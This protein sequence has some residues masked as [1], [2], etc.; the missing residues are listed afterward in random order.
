M[1]KKIK[2]KT[3]NSGWTDPSKK[4]KVRKKRKPMTE[5][6]KQ[7]A[8]ERLEKA[9]AARAAKNPNYGQSGVHESLRDL[10]DDAPIN[11]KKVKKWIKTQKELASME[12]RNEKKNVKGAFARKLIHEGYVR[13]MQKYLRDGDWVDY[14]YG[15]HQEKKIGYIC[16]AQAYYWEGPKKGEPKFNVGTYYPLLGTVYSQEMYN[17]DNG[18]QDVDVQK[19]KTRKRK[20]NK[21]TVEGKAKKRGRNT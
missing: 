5:E 18:V 19:T 21:R 8:A 1:A 4:K 17:A 20:R 15:E 7:A 12:R 9:R 13:N 11:P 6:Q 10:P 3:D 16:R 2:S 14:F